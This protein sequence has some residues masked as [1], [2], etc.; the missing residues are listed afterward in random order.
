MDQLVL[1]LDFCPQMTLHDV[2]KMFQIGVKTI[3][4]ISANFQV[5]IYQFKFSVLKKVKTRDAEQKFLK[6]SVA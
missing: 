1:E 5:E 6:Q 4:S 2:P 3:L